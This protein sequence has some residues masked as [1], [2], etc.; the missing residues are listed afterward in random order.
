M[1]LSCAQEKRKKRPQ[2]NEKRHD[3][4]ILQYDNARPPHEAEV[5]VKK[6][7]ETLKWKTLPH[8]PQYSP[9]VAP[10]HFHL[11]HLAQWHTTWLTST[12]ALMKK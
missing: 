8:L 5:V 10:S 3:K 1:H 7:I 6:C 11:T 9:D 2:D 12:S 4:V